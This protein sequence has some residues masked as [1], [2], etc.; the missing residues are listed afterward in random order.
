MFQN[1]LLRVVV[2]TALALLP[3]QM[4]AEPQSDVAFAESAA[5]CS[6]SAQ[7]GAYTYSG[8][9]L[10]GG[11]N[12]GHGAF[13]DTYSECL[14]AGQALA[15]QVSGGAC[16][17]YGAGQAYAAVEWHIVWDSQYQGQVNQ[18]YDCGDV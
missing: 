12:G 2:A 13:W 4:L 10:V 8:G 7:A 6:I 11:D 14:A 1:R 3:M 16:G 17:S 5:F 18:Q 9:Q 15:I